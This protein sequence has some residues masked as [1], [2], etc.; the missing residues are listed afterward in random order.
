MKV[1]LGVRGQWV[2]RTNG[3]QRADSKGGSGKWGAMRPR[4][5]FGG[6]S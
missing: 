5:G 4:A 1:S 6:R 3:G 2:K